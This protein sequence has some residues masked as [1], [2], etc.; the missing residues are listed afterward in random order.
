MLN[1]PSH[2]L[3]FLIHQ[4][5]TSIET[6]LSESINPIMLSIVELIK[7]VLLGWP[8]LGIIFLLLFQDPIGKILEVLPKKLLSANEI[9]IAGLSLKS[10]IKKEAQRS[11]MT[12]LSKTLPTLSPGA[13]ELLLSIEK[14]SKYGLIST[15]RNEENEITS[16][17]FPS[18]KILKNIE[19]LRMQGLVTLETSGLERDVR[20][21]LD[22]A[23]ALIN[24]IKNEHPGSGNSDTGVWVLSKPISNEENNATIMWGKTELGEKAA[25]II[26]SAVANSLTPVAETPAEPE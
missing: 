21:G 15:S 6:K 18:Q 11:G 12:D 17:Y 1:L 13:I 19:E 8:A 9:G 26:I 22:A 23:N 16:L 7:S 5:L 4:K 24:Q 3:I 25:D 10:T 2:F 20:E 14:N